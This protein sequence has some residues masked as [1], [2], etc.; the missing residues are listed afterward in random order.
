M[1]SYSINKNKTRQ[2][3]NSGMESYG[4]DTITY[5]LEPIFKRSVEHQIYILSPVKS[6][7]LEIRGLFN[8]S[9]FS[10]NEPFFCYLG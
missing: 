1:L 6:Q 3:M 4:Q 7:V 10:N 9:N 2:G 5:K 8:N